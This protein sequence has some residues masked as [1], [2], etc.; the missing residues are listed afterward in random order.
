M[1]PT[2]A[3]GLTNA[4][5]WEESVDELKVK[6]SD[7]VGAYPFTTNDRNYLNVVTLACHANK[8]ARFDLELGKD[9]RT[10][11]ADILGNRCFGQGDLAVLVHQFEDKGL[12]NMKPRLPS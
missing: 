5:E 4:F 6:T 3:I 7:T 2:S 8:G 10:A 11:E 1:V 9:R 12:G